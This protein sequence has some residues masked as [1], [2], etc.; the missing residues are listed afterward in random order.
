MTWGDPTRTNW[1]IPDDAR[2]VQED[3]SWTIY[4]SAANAHLYIYPACYHVQA[5]PLNADDL[6]RLM[7]VLATS[8]IQPQQR[9]DETKPLDEINNSKFGDDMFA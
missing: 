8:T 5:L 7:N 2:I 4:H 6:L 1:N 9:Q 3:D